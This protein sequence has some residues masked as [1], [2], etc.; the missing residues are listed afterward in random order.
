MHN[1]GIYT[2]V[3]KGYTIEVYR[4]D[5]DDS[6]DS[7]ADGSLF[8]VANHRDFYVKPPKGSTFD[9]V[10]SDYR[11]THHA[12][13]LEAYIHG[14]VSL[15][16]AGGGRFPD[17]R[18]DVSQLG[19]VFVSKATLKSKAEAR[20]AALGLVEAW[21]HYLSGEVYGYVIKKPNVCSAC[22]H[23]EAETVGSC[24]GFY[25][26]YEKGALAEARSVVDAI[27]ERKAKGKGKKS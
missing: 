21:N 25:G 12:F 6:P 15:S 1:D 10:A 9:S 8:L 26:D 27:V 14:G 5:G 16:L 4:D 24:W 13:P 3:Y 18:W 20:R 22:G 7:W 11:K 19:A 23:D 17:R 2:E